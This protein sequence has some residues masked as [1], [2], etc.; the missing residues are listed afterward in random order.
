[1]SLSLEVRK[2]MSEIMKGYQ[3][4]KETRQKISNA[5]KGVP[6]TMSEEARQRLSERMK[7]YHQAIKDAKENKSLE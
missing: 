5:K 4:S 1:M 7:R 6:S 2:Q 3:H